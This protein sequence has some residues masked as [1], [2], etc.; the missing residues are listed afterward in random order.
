MEIPLPENRTVTKIPFHVF[1]RYEIHGQAFVHFINR[2]FIISRSS[3]PQK[4]FWDIYIYIYIQ[5]KNIYI[6]IYIYSIFLNN[7]FPEQ[8]KIYFQEIGGCVFRI[9]RFFEFSDSQIWKI[10]LFKDVPTCFLYF[11]SMSVIIG[12]STGPD[13]D[14]VFEVP[15][16]IQKVLQYVREP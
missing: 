13:V 5:K 10:I 9:F 4:Y 11:W 6:Y 14:Q 16:I 7:I 2:E 1:D 8:V 15:K 3:S 12:R